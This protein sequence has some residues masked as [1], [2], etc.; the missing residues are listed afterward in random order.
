[1]A[2]PRAT[3]RLAGRSPI[4]S[5]LYR[6]ASDALDSSPVRLRRKVD[7]PA[8]LEPMMATVSPGLDGDVNAEHGLEIAVE[9]VEAPGLQQAHSATIPM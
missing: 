7:L 8:P 9:G 1:M 3:I 2:M 4:A 6:I 5:P